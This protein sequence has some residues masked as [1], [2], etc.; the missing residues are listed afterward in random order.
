MPPLSGDLAE[1]ARKNLSVVLRRLATAGQAKV[2]ESLGVSETTVSRM[3]SDGDLERVLT[4]LAL[5]GVKCV[6]I[7]VQC[8]HP[9]DIEAIFHG[10]KRWVES[11]ESPVRELVWDED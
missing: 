1:R 10:H 8:F 2:A 11:I 5:L 9:K 6:P 7:E 3:K 4:M